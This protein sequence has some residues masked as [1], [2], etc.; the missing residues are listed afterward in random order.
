MKKLAACFLLGVFL[1]GMAAAS[2]PLHITQ[3]LRDQEVILPLST[4]QRGHMAEV[5]RLTFVEDELGAG[6]LVFYDDPRTKWSIDY[7]ELYDV[8]GD[9]LVVSWIDTYGACQGAIDRGLL[10]EEDPRIDG[11]LVVID[12]GTML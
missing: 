3:N 8:Q 10:D 2:E 7:V 1:V 4:P 12:V 5:Q 11:V 6:L 9:L